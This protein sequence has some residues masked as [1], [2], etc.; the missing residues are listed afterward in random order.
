LSA[1]SLVV[2]VGFTRIALGAHF[3]T[4]V[5]AAIFFGVVWLALCVALGKP[6]RIRSQ[7]PIAVVALP[8]AAELAA[9]PSDD[10]ELPAAAI[11]RQ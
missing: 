9:V 7:S 6:M 8:I 3:L 11:S 10:P 4:D 2:V 1:I 5:L